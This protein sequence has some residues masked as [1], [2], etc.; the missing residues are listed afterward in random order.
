MALKLKV[1]KSLSEEMAETNKLYVNEN[2]IFP[3]FLQND[4]LQSLVQLDTF[5]YII[6]KCKIVQQGYVAMHDK[7]R[8]YHKLPL[9]DLICI[10][11][12]S[13]SLERAKEILLLI[14][15][16]NNN[17]IVID[18]IEFSKH[19][20]IM[21]KDQPINVLQ[22]HFIRYCG[23]L[24]HFSVIEIDQNTIS[25]CK[26]IN[27]DTTIS[28]LTARNTIQID[29]QVETP[30]PLFKTNINLSNIGIGGLDNEFQTIFRKA[31]ASR[32][33]SEKVIK[34]MGIKHVKGI[35]LY[36]P[37]GTG[38]TLLAREIGK[39]LNCEWSRVIG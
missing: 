37:P 39:L 20:K 24:I 13:F 15:T 30:S 7:Q 17:S 18:S 6:E 12:I 9:N 4:A 38:K 19:L 5:Y 11:F 31:F 14:D 27:D 33:I 22:N 21:L 35:L 10:N 23:I 36:G 2:T 32:A 1:T 29:G 3:K 26:T 34:E 25:L 8:K 28:I 16:L